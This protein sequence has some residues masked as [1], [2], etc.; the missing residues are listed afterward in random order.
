MGQLQ[1]FLLYFTWLCTTNYNFLNSCLIISFNF[2]LFSISSIISF[3][4]GFSSF[5]LFCWFFNFSCLS[6]LFFLSL[7]CFFSLSPR[8]FR[9]SFNW[10]LFLQRILFFQRI[11][12]LQLFLILFFIWCCLLIGFSLS[13][14]SSL[15]WGFS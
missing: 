1:H 10:V 7:L 12:F 5:G 2:F 3:R 11:L 15:C 6:L 4:G 14:R 8:F 9:F 13:S